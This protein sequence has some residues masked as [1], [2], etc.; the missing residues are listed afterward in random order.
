MISPHHLSR[1]A[2]ND[3][4]A[5]FFFGWL[6]ISLD[7]LSSVVAATV[8]AV[9][10]VVVGA[11]SLFVSLSSIWLFF[12]ILVA[13]GASILLPVAL[14]AALVADAFSLLLFSLPSSLLR[15]CCHRW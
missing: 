14:Y 1:K 6:V 10:V 11:S 7:Y 15:V 12:C 8:V 2:R 9:I 13:S 5:W 3:D 4:T